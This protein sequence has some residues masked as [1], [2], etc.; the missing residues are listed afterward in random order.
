MRADDWPVGVVCNTFSVVC[1]GGREAATALRSADSMS[2]VLGCWV[3]SCRLDP[4]LC[5]LT[6]F[7]VRGAGC[8]DASGER[9]GRTPAT[10]GWVWSAERDASN[11][12]NAWLGSGRRRDARNYAL[13]VLRGPPPAGPGRP[14]SAGGDPPGRRIRNQHAGMADRPQPRILRLGSVRKKVG[15]THNVASA[16]IRKIRKRCRATALQG[17]SG[18][19]LP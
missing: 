11:V 19:A 18:A 7:G 5:C 13:D 10:R 2:A 4:G 15:V 16:R 14:C 6:P 12:E 17:E 3:R 8:I 1:S 9:V